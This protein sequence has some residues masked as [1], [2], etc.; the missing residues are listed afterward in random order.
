MRC[1]KFLLVGLVALPLLVACR[2]KPSP[3]RARVQLDEQN[4]YLAGLRREQLDVRQDIQRAIDE[5][6]KEVADLD[7]AKDRVKIDGLMQR[8]A[9]LAADVAAVESAA[10]ENWLSVRAR[11]E[12]NLTN[13]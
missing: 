11:V 4:D 1:P 7:A 2:E 12:K 9:T 5:I 10:P 8:R 13:G 3:A 6:D